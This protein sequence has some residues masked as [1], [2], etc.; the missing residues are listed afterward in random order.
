MSPIGRNPAY[1]IVEV[2]RD[3][4]NDNPEF[5][6]CAPWSLTHLLY[7]NGRWLL[8]ENDYERVEE[9]D[10]MIRNQFD[11]FESPFVRQAV[12]ADFVRLL[13]YTKA[14]VVGV[15]FNG[16]DGF[17]GYRWSPDPSNDRP[18]TEESTKQT[19][20]TEEASLTDGLEDLLEIPDRPAAVQDR[21]LEFLLS[22]EKSI[23]GGALQRMRQDWIWIRPWGN[24]D[25][26]GA[27]GGSGSF[28]ALTDLLDL[29]EAEE[30]VF[31]IRPVWFDDVETRFGPA[32]S[33]RTEPYPRTIPGAEIAP[34]VQ[35]VSIVWHV[36]GGVRVGKANGLVEGE[37]GASDSVVAAIDV[38]KHRR[39]NRPMG[40]S[41]KAGQ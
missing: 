20:S 12:V 5:E 30:I 14:R 21:L 23:V 25:L 38:A 4:F 6:R 19:E 7:Q 40:L 31:R 10:R 36:Y 33:L 2:R 37:E 1:R 22:P 8:S 9:W 35:K 3:A 16:A 29:T 15:V 32:D 18:E 11:T 27:A 24:G 17:P 28:S 34:S 26:F 39:L 41:Q 13:G